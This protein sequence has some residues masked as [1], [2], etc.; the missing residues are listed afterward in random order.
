MIQAGSL[1]TMVTGLLY[2]YNTCDRVQ[3]R[4]L[5]YKG[6]T[7]V[8]HDTRR[9]RKLLGQDWGMAKQVSVQN[10]GGGGCIAVLVTF[11]MLHDRDK[12][13]LK[14][15]CKNNKNAFAL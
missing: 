3:Q 4:I 6:S 8:V 9:Q 12:V 2:V 14:V 7:D 13:L 1:E 11:C 10:K 15:C 5:G